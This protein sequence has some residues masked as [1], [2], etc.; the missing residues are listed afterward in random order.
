MTAMGLPPHAAGLLGA[1]IPDY[2]ARML[3]VAALLLAAWFVLKG[4]ARRGRGERLYQRLDPT[5]QAAKIW[6]AAAPL[7]FTYMA[8]WTVTT[9]IQQGTPQTLIDLMNRWQSTNIFG[10]A[11]QPIRVLFASAF[12][13]ADN[14]MGFLGYVFVYVLIT[15]RLEHRIGA[16]RTLVVAVVAHALGSLLTVAVEL[17]AIGRGLA[18]ESL[19]FTVDVGVSYV[20]VGSVGA[21]LWLV[22]RRWRPWLAGCL[23]LGVVTPMFI[24]HTI[25]DLGHFLATCLGAAAG[26]I[27]VRYPLREAV[28]WRQTV[29]QLTARSLPTFPDTRRPWPADSRSSAGATP[30]LQAGHPEPTDQASG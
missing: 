7:T 4:Q 8:I 9:V 28:Q 10:L 19:R 29:S 27:V 24:S 23:G 25:W 18:P 26:A 3:Q 21:Y 11:S 22:T 16:A 17:W 20:M 15:A 6:V 30:N 1:Q 2:V 14:G 5:V 13:V 12:V